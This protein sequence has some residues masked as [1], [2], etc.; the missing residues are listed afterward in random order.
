MGGRWCGLEDIRVTL[1]RNVKEY[2]NKAARMLGLD[3]GS[4]SIPNRRRKFKNL[5][6]I[7]GIT[8]G[9]VAN[10]MNCGQSVLFQ[11]W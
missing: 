9:T 1:L 3:H 7:W 11:A 2:K 8:E 5:K 4:F 10:I 6:K